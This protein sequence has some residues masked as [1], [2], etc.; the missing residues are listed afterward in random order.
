[1]NRVFREQFGAR[2][3]IPNPEVDNAYK[4]VLSHIV[5]FF[6]VISKG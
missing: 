6:S 1:M 4:C 3:D 5:C 2:D